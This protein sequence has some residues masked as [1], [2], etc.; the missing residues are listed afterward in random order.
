[1]ETTTKNEIQVEKTD[2]VFTIT[3]F[4]ETETGEKDPKSEASVILTICY[5]TKTFDITPKPRYSSC[6]KFLF[7]KTS[8]KWK[9]W[10]NVVKGIDQAI[11]AE[12][13]DKSNTMLYNVINDSEYVIQGKGL[14]FSE[15]DEIKLGLKATTAGNY[16]ISLENVD[17]LFMNQNVFL[18]DN[19]TNTI[20]D[21]KLKPYTFTTSEGV[22]NDRFKVVFKTPVSGNQLVNEND[23]VVV[24]NEELNVQSTTEKIASVLVFDVLGRKLFEVN[25]VKTNNCIIPISKRNVPLLMEINLVNG[26]K[27]NKKVVH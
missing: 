1:M 18:K 21:I 22:F 9:V 24:S 4:S 26:N 15:T 13:L 8:H 10:K 2:S 7:E 12:V 19:V 16:T 6:N 20:H 3:N 11:D 27:I 23:I 14:P 5:R 25:N 17:G